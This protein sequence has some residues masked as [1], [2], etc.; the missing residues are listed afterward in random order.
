MGPP[1]AAGASPPPSAL[2]GLSEVA[3]PA[4]IVPATSSAE[5]AITIFSATS[6]GGKLC[7]VIPRT[8]SSTAQKTRI[9]PITWKAVMSVA[10]TIAPGNLHPP[11]AGRRG[12]I[13][14]VELAR[15]RGEVD[16]ARGVLAE[17]GWRVGDD[18]A[19]APRRV[20]AVHPPDGEPG[21]AEVGE[22]VAALQ[23]G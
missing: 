5:I 14:P 22:Q 12:R 17:G 15:R 1:V 10:K 6:E 23:A 9:A 8:E 4:P 19:L 11:R 3:M 21:V 13:D 18:A 7:R 20:L 16:A 2:A